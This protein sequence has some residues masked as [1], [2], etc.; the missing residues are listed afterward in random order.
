MCLVICM[1]CTVGAVS[2]CIAK[3]PG[4]HPAG[5]GGR[6]GEEQSV[7]G[8]GGGKKEGDRGATA[9]SGRAEAGLLAAA[10]QMQCL[11][12][13]VTWGPSFCVYGMNLRV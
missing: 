8:R 5:Q 13:R 10:S 11:Y 9:T 3:F 1:E 2:H 12:L 4:D 6:D 7:S